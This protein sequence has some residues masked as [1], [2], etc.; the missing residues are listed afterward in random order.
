MG[1]TQIYK[2][3]LPNGRFVIR[4]EE[5]LSNPETT[6]TTEI[7]TPRF[8]RADELLDAVQL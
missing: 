8:Q 3:K 5:K 6:M 7:F 4:A 2:H 1:H